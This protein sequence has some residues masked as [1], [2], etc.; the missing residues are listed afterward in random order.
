VRWSADPAL[1]WALTWALTWALLLLPAVA[2]CV[3]LA[4]RRGES[5][6]GR[7]GG[8][9]VRKA[10]IAAAAL[11]VGK[12]RTIAQIRIFHTLHQS[13]ERIC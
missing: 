11:T 2:H 7:A 10:L 12:R 1:S 13:A 9:S 4:G 8:G 6:T 5:P 3:G